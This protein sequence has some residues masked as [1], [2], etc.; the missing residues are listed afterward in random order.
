M[1]CVGAILALIAS[2]IVVGAHF[3]PPSGSS[4][5]ATQWSQSSFNHMLQLLASGEDVHLRIKNQ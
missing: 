1:R 3:H 5:R 4:P 2:A